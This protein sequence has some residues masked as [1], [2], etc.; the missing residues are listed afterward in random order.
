MGVLKYFPLMAAVLLVLADSDARAVDVVGFI[1]SHK[2]T[3]KAQPIWKEAKFVLKGPADY[4]AVTEVYPDELRPVTYRYRISGSGIGSFE[5][6]H[7]SEGFGPVTY[8]LRVRNAPLGTVKIT[9]HLKGSKSRPV[10]IGSL[11]CVKASELESLLEWDRFTIM[12][13]IPDGKPEERESWLN[14][15][16]ANLT[17]RPEHRINIGFSSEIYYANRDR[18]DV[19]RQLALCEAWAKKYKLP[20]MLGLVSWWAGTPVHVEDGHGG[21]F[22]DVKYQQICYSPDFESAENAD[23][24]TLLGERYDGHY[25]LSVPNQWSNCP[26]LTMNSPVLNAYRVQRLGEA[27]EELKA[28]SG[29][30]AAWIKAIYLENEPR[31]WDSDCEAGNPNSKRKVLWADFNP[32]VVENAKK[33]GVELNPADGLSN[34]ELA[35]LHRNVG[36]YN[37]DT[38]DAVNKTRAA[39]RFAE[40]VP[41]YTHSLELRNMFPGGWINHPASEWAYADGARTGIEGMWSQPSDFA[42]VREWGPWSNLNREENDGR[43]IDLHLWDL[44]VSYMLGADLYNSYNWHA[45]GAQRFF[46]YV[47]EFLAEFPIVE[48]APAE[49]RFV[50][51]AS[52]KMKTPMK[53][54]AFSRLEVQVKVTKKIAGAAFLG[55][56]FDDGWCFISQQQP[57]SLQPGIRTL[58]IDFATPAEIPHDKEALVALS[59]FDSKGKMV[60]DAVVFTPESAQAIKLI[61]DL[62]TQRALS[63]FVINNAKR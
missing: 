43:H 12:G 28:V 26:W 19:R 47:K 5:R 51:R 10:L 29:G 54:Q 49:A 9:N 21:R 52:L 33:D 60:P 25:G 57:I 58:G 20:V 63:L 16:A 17:A 27:I 3:F 1:G 50:D 48:L 44:R 55:I 42:R 53:L 41:L 11:R 31:Y 61:L 39:H 36:R 8:F 32:L 18:A 13:L 45:I 7:A 4:L 35:W 37:Q 2:L 23:L 6:C 56:A 38:V 22:G 14:M 24:K 34:D 15:L 40:A 59:V 30:S 46:D 62:R